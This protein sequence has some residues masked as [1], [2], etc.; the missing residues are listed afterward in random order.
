MVKENVQRFKR[1]MD[2][3]DSHKFKLPIDQAYQFEADADVDEIKNMG[4]L[5][6]MLSKFF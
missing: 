5:K 6:D 3:V 4:K 1:F 2:K